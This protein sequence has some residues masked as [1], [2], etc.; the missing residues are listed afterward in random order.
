M[1]LDLQEY[2]EQYIE[3]Y[4]LD[5]NNMMIT[6]I[7]LGGISIN[8]EKG[9]EL[10]GATIELEDGWQFVNENT[11]KKIIKKQNI[12]EIQEDV[13]I[14]QD[15]ETIFLEKGDRIKVLT[16]IT[17]ETEEVDWYSWAKSALINDDYSG[18]DTTDKKEVMNFLSWIK[19]NFGRDAY[20]ADVGED[21]FF[22]RP[23]TIPGND[24]LKGQVS[25]YIIAM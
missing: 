16:E 5:T 19:D 8:P 6:G 21:E 18:L 15:N 23:Q 17:L 14:N 13:K 7:S 20:I 12:I 22:G 3:K 11:L 25:T 1:P 2:L 24:N 4:F 10:E 9:V